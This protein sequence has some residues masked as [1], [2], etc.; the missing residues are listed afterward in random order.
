MPALNLVVATRYD[1]FIATIKR[2]ENQPPLVQVY[3]N[4]K[5]KLVEV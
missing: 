5:I 3:H 2:R 1:C 4:S